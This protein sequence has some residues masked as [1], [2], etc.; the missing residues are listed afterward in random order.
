MGLRDEEKEWVLEETQEGGDIRIL[1]GD[2]RCCRDGMGE[3]G[4]SGGRG[5]LYTYR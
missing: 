2:A 4:A 3:G 1:T 5:Y